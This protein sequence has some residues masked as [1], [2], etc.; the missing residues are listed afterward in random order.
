MRLQSWPVPLNM[1]GGFML[2][3]PLCK[4]SYLT[5]T[6]DKYQLTYNQVTCESVIQE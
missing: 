5:S 1:A 3:N 6:M 4:S 2:G